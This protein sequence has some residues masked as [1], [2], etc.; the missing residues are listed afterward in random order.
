MIKKLTAFWTW[1]VDGLTDA[2]M[3]V[4]AT[5]AKGRSVELLVDNEKGIL[6]EPSGK[7]LGHVLR[8]DETLVTEPPDLHAAL[9]GAQLDVIVPERLVLHR[10]LNPIATESMPF[11][12]AFVRHQIERVTP[13]RAADAYFAVST[14]HM[15][16]KPPKVAI[17]LHAVARR[18]V[19]H[20]IV[21]AREFKPARLRLLLP[22]L[23]AEKTIVPIDDDANT[24][25]GTI[26]KFLQI[27]VAS[28]IALLIARLAFYP[29][30]IASVQSQTADL[31]SEIEDQE[32]TLSALR[33]G[34]GH[35][36]AAD[37]IAIR[38]LHP[39]AVEILEN[40]SAALPDDDYLTSMELSNNGL[41]VSGISK[42]PSDLVPALEGSR[43]FRE[44]SFAEP[45][46]R[47]ESGTGN[48][49]HLSMLVV[50]AAKGPQ[51]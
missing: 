6:R 46:T 29:A 16:G 13:W 15:D 36:G 49:F 33:G 32:A 2:T 18:L 28:V 12:D 1:L 9:Q 38:Q 24:R 44:V 25:R 42:D 14:S 51:R 20:A 30:Q 35:F 22:T 17:T 4:A 5:F 34:T 10:K 47:V 45:I 43:H 21:T 3:I 7:K 27:A 37:L 19:D 11:L 50:T 31:E 41:H 40:L 39:R 23:G 26:R 8:L 48:R